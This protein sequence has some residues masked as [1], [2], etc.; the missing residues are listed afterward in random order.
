M[1]RR[2]HPDAVAAAAE[3][4]LQDSPAFV[5]F[6][7]PQRI[8]LEAKLPRVDA[9]LRQ[10]RIQRFVELAR[11]HLVPFRCPSRRLEAKD[12]AEVPK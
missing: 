11:Q 10:L 1:E 4:T 6:R 2:L 12:R 8:E 9:S 3:E 7:G 5:I